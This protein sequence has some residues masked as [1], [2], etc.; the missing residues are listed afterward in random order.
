MNF[1]DRHIWR[2]VRRAHDVMRLGLHGL[3]VGE[4]FVLL[5]EDPGM[6]SV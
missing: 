3:G 5:Q 6:G 1:W 4:Y 2:S